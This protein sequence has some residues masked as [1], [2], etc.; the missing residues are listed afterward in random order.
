MS[1]KMCQFYCRGKAWLAVWSPGSGVISHF[2][3]THLNAKT[4]SVIGV[5]SEPR[6]VLLQK[7]PPS[8]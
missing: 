1:I 3:F 8:L 4:W 2:E 6:S 7:L 5:Y